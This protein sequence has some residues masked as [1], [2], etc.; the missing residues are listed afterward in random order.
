MMFE[1]V[2][3]LAIVGSGIVSMIL[4][5][6]WYGPLFG[7]IW[8]ELQGWSADQ[9]KA[10]QSQSM[11]KSY[12][13]MFVGS[14]VLAAVL[15]MF[16]R[17]VGALTITDGLMVGFW[18]WLGFALPLLLSS[19]LWEGKSWKLYALNAGYNLVQFAIIGAIV[20]LWG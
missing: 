5:Y 17:T 14:L 3:I 18:A 4:G 15:G 19:V 8:S 7:K 1:S 13:M 9:M 20:T 6:I 2:S 12:G 11:M 16:A 10:K